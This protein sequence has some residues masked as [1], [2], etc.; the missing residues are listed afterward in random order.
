MF[1]WIIQHE[2]DPHSQR[3]AIS[4]YRLFINRI[5]KDE[6]ENVKAIVNFSS[7][8]SNLPNELK[9]DALLALATLSHITSN[10]AYTGF[11][12]EHLIKL[13]L[14][15][16][17]TKSA[18]LCPNLNPHYP[19]SNPAVYYYGQAFLLKQ[20][21]LTDIGHFQEAITYPEK[22]ADL[23]WLFNLDQLGFSYVQKFNLYAQANIFNLNLMLGKSEVLDGYE[24]FLIKHPTEI[25]PSI[26]FVLDSAD[27]FG[28][29]I[30][31]FLNRF[32]SLIQ[33]YSEFS[34]GY[35]T[36]QIT[37]NR[38]VLFL[39]KLSVYHYNRG[40]YEESLQAAMQSWELSQELN[41]HSHLRMFA[42][43]A[44]M[45]NTPGKEA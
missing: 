16:F 21:Y 22:Y 13:C 20:A 3:M 40:R 2:T 38:Y 30:D 4:Q 36:E 43:L 45:Y 33:S 25:L 24:S 42:S 11:F 39:Q 7:Y 35:Y 27:H 14:D 37:R 31:G 1:K 15:L 19:L 17:G 18:P 12:S 41:N 23:S 34:K 26:I 9:L 5:S 10:H 28:F 6:E 8:W 32:Y 44:V 29:E